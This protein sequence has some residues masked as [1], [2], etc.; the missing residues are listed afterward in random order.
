M[1]FEALDYL[2]LARR[3]IEKA[4]RVT[5]VQLHDEAA[6]LAYLAAF[7]AAQAFLFD[8]LGRAMKTH[9]GVQAEFGRVARE[10][11]ALPVWMHPFLSNAFE[12]KTGAD[13]GTGSHATVAPDDAAQVMERAAAFVAIIDA[14]LGPLDRRG[15]ENA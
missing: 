9:A 2:R 10:P 14:A 15:A 5:H 7:H 8:R 4:H 11:P 13:Y 6:R 1:T 3:A 12:Y